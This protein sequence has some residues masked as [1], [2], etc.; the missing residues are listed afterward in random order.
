MQL[1]SLTLTKKEVLVRETVPK[2][3]SCGVNSG[4]VHVHG[5]RIAI[6]VGK[7][8]GSLTEKEEREERRRRACDWHGWMM[9]ITR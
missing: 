6:M 2:N 7:H 4:S 8:K 3:F 5:D 1:T 9:L